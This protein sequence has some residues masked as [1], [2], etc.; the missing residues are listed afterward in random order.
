MTP[1]PL[2]QTLDDFAYLELWEDKYRYLIDMGKSLPPL[3][4]SA[5]SPQ[6]KVQGCVSQVWLLSQKET[7]KKGKPILKF[8]GQSDAHIVRGLI[9]LLLQI[10]SGK[11]PE[12]ILQTD[13]REIFAQLGLQDHLTP[14]RSN[15]FGAMVKRIQKIAS[16]TQREVSN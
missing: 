6:N 11:T 5:L 2:A 3:P 9:A 10:Y 13:A 15:G 7:R 12:Q 4:Q 8:K 16:E 1:D 14:Q